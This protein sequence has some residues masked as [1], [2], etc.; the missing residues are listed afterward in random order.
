VSFHGFTLQCGLR[1]NYFYDAENRIVQVNG[2]MGQCS[3]ATACYVYDAEGH[4]VRATVNGQPMSTVQ[5]VET[6]ILEAV[7][8]YIGGHS[9]RLGELGLVYEI[10]IS[11]SSSDSGGYRSEVLVEFSDENGPWDMLEFEVTR[12]ELVVSIDDVGKWLPEAFSS[13]VS[14]RQEEAP[15]SG[16]TIVH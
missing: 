12:R 3:R 6:T 16:Q 13:V 5:E 9:K 10:S 7:R 4:R 2:T 1:N 15:D 14:R 8:E 11:R